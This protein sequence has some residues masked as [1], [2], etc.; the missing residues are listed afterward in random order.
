MDCMVIK[1]DY[2]DLYRCGRQIIIWPIYIWIIINKLYYSLNHECAQSFSSIQLFVNPWTV[3]C[4]AFM[5]MEFSRQEYKSWV[6][7]SYSRGSFWSRN[8]TYISCIS[9]IGRWILYHCATWEIL[10]MNDWMTKRD[11]VHNNM[12]TCFP[13]IVF[14]FVLNISDSL[15]SLEVRDINLFLNNYLI[16]T[17]NAFF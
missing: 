3:A 17:E 15:F 11:N 8:Q 10:T 14:W 4:Q 7:I 16:S 5:S 9:C 13:K 2:E 1:T 12:Y 6:V